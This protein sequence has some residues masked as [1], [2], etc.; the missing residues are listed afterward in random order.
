MMRTGVDSMGTQ[1]ATPGELVEGLQ[2][3]Q[4]AA[5]RRLHDWFRAPLAKLLEQIIRRHQLPHATE[6]LLVHALHLAETFLRTRPAAEAGELSWN[7]F[8]G[9]LLLQVARMIAQPFGQ[10]GGAVRALPLPESPAYESRSY[11]QPYERIGE[12]WFGGDW[13]GGVR[14]PDGSLWVLVA[15]VT[16]HGYHAYLLASALPGLWEQCWRSA[17]ADWKPADCLRAMHQLVESCLPD[18][19]YVECTLARFEPDGSVTVGPAGGSRLVL[20]RQGSPL[21]ELI[22]LRGGWLGLLPPGQGDEHRWQ[23]APGD[24]LLL[25]TDGLFDQLS[26]A[27]G[28]PPDLAPLLKDSGS[29]FDHL[30]GLLRQSLAQIPQRDDITMLLLRRRSAGEAVPLPTN[31]TGDVPV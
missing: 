21:P 2:Q 7:A 8:R 13:Y 19:I 12:A 1:Y 25:A 23:L 30:Q 17:R 20:R 28:S 3:R 10:P 4:E 26:G 31:G 24:E 29:L 9:M 14:A 22:K 16:G 27:D 18:G 11:F 5:R 15:D 6:R